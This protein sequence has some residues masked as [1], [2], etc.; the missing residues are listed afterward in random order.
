MGLNILSKKRDFI[1]GLSILWI[2]LFHVGSYTRIVTPTF[3][4]DLGYSGVDIFILLSGYGCYYSLKRDSNV[5]R[6]LGRRLRRL[7][8]SYL[9]FI[10]IYMAWRCLQQRMYFVEICGNLTMT[11]WWNGDANQFN[12]YVD[13]IVLFYILAPYLCG[14]IM[15]TK[16]PIVVSAG[17]IAIA[18]VISFSFMHGQLLIAMCRLPIF[19]LGIF[20]ARYCDADS[21]PV[22]IPEKAIIIIAN[23]LIPIGILLLYYMVMVQERWDKWHYGLFWY[24]ITLYAL[25]IA[26][27]L[28]VIG[29]LFNKISLLRL[30]AKLLEEIGKASFEI[31][32]V[33]ML[34]YEIAVA[35]SEALHI[36]NPYQWII[37]YLIGLIL[38]YLY[39]R[40][41]S[42]IMTNKPVRQMQINE[43]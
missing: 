25:G 12:W 30:L 19:I 38:G 41:I 23:I 20:L 13:A 2:M 24:P 11:G 39:H 42:F 21:E 5:V 32:L 43:K 10:I 34:V 22:R 8:P 27:D 33:H 36:H 28:G 17:L 31:F 29:K 4:E 1:M 18:Y 7:L 37:V 26:I 6:F 3:F 9:P 14:I 15:K 16:R 40:L 35:K